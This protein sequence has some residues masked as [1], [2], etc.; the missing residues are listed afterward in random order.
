MSISGAF[1]NAVN[2]AIEALEMGNCIAVVAAGNNGQ[3]SCAYSPSSASNVL[4]V[5]AIDSHDRR[6]VFP[7]S[8]FGKCVKI[9]APGY[10][11][12]STYIGGGGA[13]AYMR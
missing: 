9:L 7:S 8:N 4:N 12:K 1:S 13:T 10:V 11:I 2:R 6:L 5:A 3:N